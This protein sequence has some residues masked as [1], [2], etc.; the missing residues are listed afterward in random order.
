MAYIENLNLLFIHVPKNA[1]KSI[2]SSLGI[3]T[4]KLLQAPR[5]RSFSNLVAKYLLNKTQNRMARSCL[6]GSFDYVLCAQH[7]SYQ[8]IE[9]LNLIPRLKLQNVCS[10]AVIRNPYDRALSTYRHFNKDTSLSGFKVFWKNAIGHSILDHNVI[11][12][13]RT[14]RSFVVNAHDEIAVSKLLR[15]ERLRADFDEFVKKSN[16][17]VRPLSHLGRH[18]TLNYEDFYDKDAKLLVQGIFKE[19]FDEFSY[20]R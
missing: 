4:D 9:F 13:L 5:T 2:E 17:S 3:A 12:H 6:F 14:Q 19:D 15:F 1:G 20:E 16:I 7:L 10:F 11:A 18:P 8:E